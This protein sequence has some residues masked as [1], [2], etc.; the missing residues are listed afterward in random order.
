MADRAQ[1][2]FMNQ[3]KDRDLLSIEDLATERSNVLSA[4]LDSMSSLE[5]AR[6]INAEDAKVA[7][8]V[9]RALP[10]IAHA[11]DWIADALKTGGRL[12]YVGTGTS[13]RIAALDAAECPPTFNTAP[14]MVQFVIA[15]GPEALSMPVEADEDSCELGIREI[16]KKRPGKKD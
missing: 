9:E 14:E 12:I 1:T 5:I 3:T 11:I 7:G 2:I 13:G 16:R 8:T 6:I 15:G 10:K 4:D